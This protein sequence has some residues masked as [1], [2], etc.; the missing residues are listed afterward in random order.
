MKL[1]RFFGD[2]NIISCLT[3]ST[4]FI[5]RS[6]LFQV[7]SILKKN[8]SCRSSEEVAILANMKDIVQEVNYRNQRRQETLDRNKE[9]EDEHFILRSKCKR[10]AVAIENAKHLVV[11]IIF[12]L[13]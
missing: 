2:H 8:E 1:H 10:L 7:S 5:N 11:S 3:I 9:I 6:I 13:V 4:V 12:H